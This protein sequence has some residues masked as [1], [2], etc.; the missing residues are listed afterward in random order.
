VPLITIY[1]VLALT[2]GG[3]GNN[4]GAV[5][6]AFLVVFFMESTRFLTSWLPGLAPVQV[7]AVGESLIGMSLIAVLRFRRDGLVPERI[8]RLDPPPVP[9]PAGDPCMPRPPLG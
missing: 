3:T 4:Y 9:A 1:I 5:L 6:G 2:A 8:T 7:A